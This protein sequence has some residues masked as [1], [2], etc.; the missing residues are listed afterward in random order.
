MTSLSL[1]SK[2]SD[3]D[4]L[5][6]NIPYLAKVVAL[7]MALDYACL[8][9][10]YKTIDSPLTAM[11]TLGL[12]GGLFGRHRDA[13][14]LAGLTY[15]AG[16]LVEFAADYLKDGKF[17]TA[18]PHLEQN[19]AAYGLAVV[20]GAGAKYLKDHWK[21]KTQPAIYATGRFARDKALPGVGY[22][23]SKTWNGIKGLCGKF[24]RKKQEPK[25]ADPN[26]QKIE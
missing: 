19:L 8:F 2:L 23:C 21:D 14:M 20:A 1:E 26:V 12:M 7:P 24:R 22:A 15:G 16:K 17:N 10:N 6:G 4:L 3:K 25:T 18:Q 9:G 5:T 13:S 11:A